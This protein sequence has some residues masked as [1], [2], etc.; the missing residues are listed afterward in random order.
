M[1]VLQ[2]L[3]NRHHTP[4]IIEI[5]QLLRHNQQTSFKLIWLKGHAGIEGNEMADQLANE[6][7][8]NSDAQNVTAPIPTSHLKRILK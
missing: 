5:Q 4:T 1:S 8:I 2:A 3:K 7:A 6:A